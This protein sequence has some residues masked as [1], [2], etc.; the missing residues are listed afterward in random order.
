MARIAEARDYWIAP[1]A[2][3]ITLNALG[4]PDRI[5][6]SVATGAAILC[7]MKGVQGLEY[8]NGHNYKSWPLSLSPTFFNTTT[9]K[10][11]YVAIPKSQTV[12]TQAVI[13]FPSQKLDVNGRAEG[14]TNATTG[15]ETPGEQIGSEDY[16]YIWLQGII[17]ASV[18]QESATQERAWLQEIQT[19]TLSTDEAKS[20]TDT[21]WYS[22]SRVAN[23]VTF[24]KEITM[25]AGSKFLELKADL[26]IL[27]GKLLRGVVTK[28]SVGVDDTSDEYVV[29]PGY[30][31]KKYLRKDID[32]TAEGEI[33]FKKGLKVGEFRSRIFGSG[34]VIDEEGNAEFES[35]YSRS[36]ISTPEFRFNRIAVTEGE[37]WCT[38]GYGTIKEVE[39]I[40]STEGYITLKLEENDWASVAEGDICRGI[41]N[42]IA[43]DYETAD[44]DDDTELYAAPSEADTEGFGFSSKRGFFTSYFWVTCLDPNTDVKCY[45]RRG[46]CCFKYQL[47]HAG[48]PHPCA[49]MKFAQYGSFTRA[50]RRSSSYATSIGHY[51]EMVLDGVQT[52]KIQ[53]ANIVYRKGYLG[54]MTV[55]VKVKDANGNYT[56]ETRSV[57]LRGYGLYVQDNVY[58]GNAVIQLDPVTLEEL[59]EQLKFYDVSLTEYIDVITVDDVGNCIGG[60]YTE[61]GNNNEY[62]TYRIQTTLLVR[63]NGVLLLLAED[64]EDAGKGTYKINVQNHGCTTMIQGSTI[65]I[66]GIS[67]IKDGV[68]GSGDDA[69]FDY[70]AMRQMS[71]CSVDIIVDC[72]GKGVITKTLPV[73]IK[74][75][76]QPFVGADITNKFSAVSWNTRTQQ[77]VGLPIAFD[78]KM[79]KNNEPLDV[80][81][82]N[83]VCQTLDPDTQQPVIPAQN[84]S[85]SIV[86]VNGTKQARIAIRALSE[87]LPPVA[88]LAVTTS[89][90]YA[91]VSYERTLIHTINK[92]TDT[93]VYS[94][95]PSV[96]EIII[97]K[98]EGTLSEDAL[99]CAVI[100]DSSDN[101]HYNVPYA[102][103]AKHKVALYYRKFY[104]DGTSDAEETP[105]DNTAITVNSAMAEVRFFLYGRNG[106]NVDRSV[107]HD[108]ES[109]PIIAEGLDGKGVEYIFFQ[110]NVE[111]PIPTIDDEEDNRQDD[112]Y[113]PYNTQGTQ[114]W[115]DEPVGVGAN[116][117][118]EF[119][120]QRKKVNGVWQPFGNVLLWNRYT[121]DGTSPYIIDL[122]NEQSF[123]NCDQNGEVTGS[124]ESSRL[125]L[126]KGTAYAFT[127]FNI[128]ITPVGIRCNEKT[129]EFSLSDSDK[130]TAQAQGYY[131][132]TPSVITTPSAHINI[133]VTLRT[134]TSIKLVAVY[135]INKNYAG[136]EGKDAVYYSLI[137]TL[138]VIHKNKNGSFRDTYLSVQVNKVQGTN[139]TVL[140]TYAKLNAEGLKLTYQGSHSS[141]QTTS[142]ITSL[143]TS[144]L[145]GQASW[146]KL[147][148]RKSS[149]NTLLDSERINVVQDGQDGQDGVDGDDGVVFKLLPS[150][151]MISFARGSDGR[152]LTPSSVQLSCGYVKSE[153]KTLTPY[154]GTVVDNL[155]TGGGAPYSIMYRFKSLD[156]S[157]NPVNGYQWS[158]DL[159]EDGCLLTIPNNTDYIAI[160]FILTSA[161]SSYHYDENEHPGGV[162]A[163]N[164]I[165]MVTVAIKKDGEKGGT[166][167]AGEGIFVNDCGIYTPG[168]MY[169]YE[170]NGDVWVRDMVRYEIGGIMYGFLVKTKGLSISDAPSSASGDDYWE[171]AG[172]VNTVIA[173]T[174]F[175]TN[176]NIGGFMASANKLATSQIAYR[177]I[178][179]GTYQGVTNKAVYRGTWQSGTTYYGS[180]YDSSEGIAYKDV[181]AY[182]GSYYIPKNA[183]A[184][185]NTSSPPPANS[186][187]WQTINTSSWEY[188]AVENGKAYYPKAPYEYTTDADLPRRHMVL[189]NNV[190]YVVKNQGGKIYASLPSASSLVW[191]PASREE[192]AAVNSRLTENGEPY[193]DIP[194]FTIDG[195]E[196][197]IMMKQRDD[198]QWSVDQTGKQVL[199]VFGGQRVEIS[200]TSK[201]ISIFDE[202]GELSSSFDGGKV[203]N[204]AALF[205]DTT[206]SVSTTGGKRSAS[207]N[208][209]IGRVDSGIEL[210][211]SAF[212]VNGP[213]TVL[214]SYNLTA[215]GEV[216][217]NTSPYAGGAS[218]SNG[219]MP[220]P[221]KV[222][223]YYYFRNYATLRI[224]IVKENS[225]GGYTEVRTLVSIMA[226][227][228][229]V[230]RNETNISSYIPAA[231][232]YYIAAIYSLGVY[233]NRNYDAYVQWSD[234]SLSFTSNIYLAR[235][236]ANG[237][238]Y[239][240]SANNFVAAV[241]EGG[242][243]L[244]F[245]CVTNNGKS[246]IEVSADGIK[247]MSNGIWGKITPTILIVHVDYSQNTGSLT[248]ITRYSAIG[249]TATVEKVSHGDEGQIKVTFPSGFSNL[250]LHLE[251]TMVI[252]TP[253]GRENVNGHLISF[254]GSNLVAE[255]NDDTSN[256]LSSFL[257]ELKY[258]G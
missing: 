228:Q 78:M 160:E 50:D 104:H 214:A 185:S 194:M 61:S 30:V 35:I 132:L 9:A 175:G 45:S 153:G 147:F 101:K 139:V 119:Y 187:E 87:G 73:S 202:N 170:S 174:V 203:Q 230:R 191:R 205:G 182:S 112:N 144:T 138:N 37:Q 39:R 84:I 240:S 99:T 233:P 212:T 256:N 27:A 26:F 207:G 149:D 121:T 115:T 116:S 63:K 135:K 152:T 48:V 18:D 122:S 53:S 29:T 120:A 124:Y 224:C 93:N 94:L 70:E 255:F 56:G 192:I 238:S 15:E 163:D 58:F 253:Y 32:D 257:L 108:Q 62:R 98:N 83:V 137:P 118:F 193:L 76:S 44:L 127:D 159:E 65:Y 34:A 81:G 47:R 103:F 220:A 140:D 24:L 80:M 131:E 154:S 77:Y 22:F 79:W 40:S 145:C 33:T 251:N 16:Y 19:G 204:M 206:G 150:T 114:Q 168:T 110:Q 195:T 75:D 237:F 95:L 231:G 213:A 10:Y 245:K 171:A 46:E 49:F 172:I 25:A 226:S 218:G 125:M 157:Y 148:L 217:T 89:A 244:R 143:S 188:K 97:N 74:H 236:F 43:G 146:T 20:T 1:E 68:A 198:T 197:T 107:L 136:G 85:A 209:A 216:F 96:S 3:N 250:N 69:S 223:G 234:V 227:G 252:I 229:T 173:N 184:V 165:D 130:T 164:I 215:N 177:I 200:P 247:A 156:G 54:D 162:R 241:N 232:T 248:A 8:D 113:C 142:S 242:N 64:D 17:S 67:H 249:G 181:V 180:A 179:R 123:I 239:G 210:I 166:G 105:Y 235:I 246:G 2:V 71:H 129:S 155:W 66:T 106:D 189:Y 88:E 55:E 141:E 60:L 258:F 176:A 41:Y 201:D 254:N 158:K 102:D 219:T 208:G 36:F 178:Y 100:C 86:T 134:N 183:G 11:V 23:V 225:N 190:Y 7:Y 92:S 167:P 4:D 109:V 169:S 52:W 211:S 199:G 222:G 59:T 133:E 14:T 57:E 28:D 117:R 13:V 6:G 90:T 151:T 38:N 42:D 21:D 243:S 31:N 91:G 72:E 196:G 51:Y 5:Q 82:V 161:Y 111:T 126:F 186:S 128:K 221:E 12:G